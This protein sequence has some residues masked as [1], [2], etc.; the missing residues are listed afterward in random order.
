MFT[1]PLGIFLILVL[2]G[3]NIYAGYEVA[4]F[5]GHSVP[6]V[7][8]A[9]ALVPLAGPLVFLAMKTKMPEEQQAAEQAAAGTAPAG[10]AGAPNTPSRATAA[11]AASASSAQDRPAAPEGD[12][13]DNPMHA[14]GAAPSSLHISH[15]EPA[16]PK[17]P[18]ATTYQRGQFTFN[19][20]FFETRF[21]GMFGVVKR[22]ADKDMVLI[23][24]AA[25]GE[26]TGTRISRIAASDLHLQ[27][28]KGGA[29]EEV[30]IPFTEI[31]EIRHKHKDA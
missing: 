23:I 14:T 16:K 29:S 15:E 25:R 7:C 24:K 10:A 11:P 20:R 8:G 19:R 6:K 31:Q 3:A 2:Y 28:E 21:P 9:A 22:D 27:V 18:P 1:A 30:L 17:H 4:I 5:R 12:D 13:D 26:F